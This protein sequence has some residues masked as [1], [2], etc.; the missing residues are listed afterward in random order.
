[1]GQLARSEV[2]QA[3]GTFAARDIARARHLV[4]LDGDIN[5][6]NRETVTRAVEIGDDLEVREW[7][8]FMIL[9]A[10]CLERIAGNTIDVAEQTVCVVTG[11]FRE[12]A[13]ESQPS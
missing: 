11:L 2:E 4:G 13:D 8:M 7:A 9:V 1:M 3:K 5:R 10:R 6:L 12:F